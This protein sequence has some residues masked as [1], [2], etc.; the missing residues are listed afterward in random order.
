M[1][2]EA[3]KATDVHDIMLKLE[4]DKKSALFILLSADE[5]INRS[6]N[7]TRENKNFDL[8]IGRTDPVPLRN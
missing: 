2:D 8:F 5:T 7:G 4:V 1:T 3:K 6:G